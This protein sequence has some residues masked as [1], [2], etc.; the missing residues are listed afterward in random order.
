MTFSLSFFFCEKD[1]DANY[2]FSKS[3]IDKY[4]NGLDWTWTRQV[5]VAAL[6]VCRTRNIRLHL[7]D[8]MGRSTFPFFIMLCLTFNTS[9]CVVSPSADDGGCIKLLEGDLLCPINS[10]CSNWAPDNTV[11]TVH[12]EYIY[13]FLFSHSCGLSETSHRLLLRWPAASSSTL[14]HHK[15]W[16][17]LKGSFSQSPSSA[18]GRFPAAEQNI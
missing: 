5:S 10:T 12:G 4:L 17:E 8:V 15:P 14:S 7:V 16:P 9:S 18:A 6:S 1:S 13:I 11:F 3:S 2:Y